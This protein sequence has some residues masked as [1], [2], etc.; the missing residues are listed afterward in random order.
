M[1]NSEVQP[2]S[3]GSSQKKRR[4]FLR[5]ILIVVILLVIAYLGI[6]AYAAIVL[7]KPKRNFDPGL[8]PRRSVIQLKRMAWRSP[9]GISRRMTIKT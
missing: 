3:K 9:R 5:V 6:S 7:T 2:S 4:T 1:N 8:N